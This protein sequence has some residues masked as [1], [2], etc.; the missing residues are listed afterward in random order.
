MI[1]RIKLRMVTFLDRFLAENP[2]SPLPVEKKY[3]A[4]KDWFWVLDGY[5]KEMKDDKQRHI[6]IERV[7]FWQDTSHGITGLVSPELKGGFLALPPP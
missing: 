5:G 3:I 4:A 7:V 1:Q 6:D 2:K